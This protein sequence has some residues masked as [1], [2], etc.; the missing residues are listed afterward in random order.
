MS[1]TDF[2]NISLNIF[3]TEKKQ[4]L[5]INTFFFNFEQWEKK[6]KET[7]IFWENR[8]HHNLLLRFMDL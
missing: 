3:F 8:Q 5:S 2:S 4:I 1:N 6:I 7:F